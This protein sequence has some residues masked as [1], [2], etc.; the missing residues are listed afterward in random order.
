MIPIDPGVSGARRAH[1]RRVLVGQLKR[2]EAYSLERATDLVVKS[3]LEERMLARLVRKG[4][5]KP[6]MKGGYW[7]DLERYREC[8]RQELIVVIGAI[9]VMA[10]V[11]ACALL[12]AKPRDHRRPRAETQV[13][14]PFP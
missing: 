10:G 7:L 12:Y 5:V 6:G 3:R 1:A 4:I 14:F 2:A 13:V 9:L 11:M 8:R